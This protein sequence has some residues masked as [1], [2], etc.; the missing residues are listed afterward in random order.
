MDRGEGPQSQSQ[1]EQRKGE[2]Q[3]TAW[4]SSDPSP[5]L[6]NIPDD[7]VD[8]LPTKYGGL[9]NG[10]RD[11]CIVAW[12]RWYGLKSVRTCYNGSLVKLGK[13]CT[14]RLNRESHLYIY[15]YIYILCRYMEIPNG[16][17]SPNEKQG[18]TL[19][20]HTPNMGNPTGA[21]MTGGHQ[22]NSEEGFQRRE[23]RR[24]FLLM[25]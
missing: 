10:R 19:T 6:S 23:D 7:R 25:N 16:K 8:V 2:N 13:S 3:G 24:G 4:E 21:C 9:T 14:A 11:A 18:I 20:N 15:V 22:V 17:Y 5:Q 12:Q 1:R